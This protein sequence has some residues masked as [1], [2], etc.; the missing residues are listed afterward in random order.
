M[1][2]RRTAAAIVAAVLLIAA[3]LAAWAWHARQDPIDAFLQQHWQRPLAPQGAPPASFSPLEAALSPQA[4]G[5]CHVQQYADWK[6]SLHSH[7]MEAGVQWQFHLMSQGEANR[8]MNCHAPLAEQ[9]ALVARAR[10]WPQAPKTAPPA[11]VDAALADDGLVC[12]GCHVRAHQ[13]YGPP[14]KAAQASAAGAKA[15]GGYTAS[16]AFE[17]SRFCASCHQFPADGPSINGKL[18][19]DTYQQWKRSPYAAAGTQCQG[20][21][22]PD[23]RHQWQ[24]IHSAEMLEKALEVRLQIVGSGDRRVAEASLRNVGAGHDLPTYMVPKI[25]A[26][27]SLLDAAGNTRAV[28]SQRVIG[29]R[30][31]VDL[32]HEDFDTRLAPGA[33]L[34]WSS[35]ISATAPGDSVELRVDVAPREHYER[36]FEHSLKDAARLPADT[37]ALLQRARADAAA[38]RYQAFR[39]REPLQP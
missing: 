22:M 5:R 30:V 8:C 27:L 6:Q 12:A 29:W 25:T 21:H 31:N 33:A 38:T 35:A 2:R 39:I 15:H 16:A 23:R 11:F 13:R 17:D 37:L 28:L 9:K 3:A 36:S 7:T 14:P 20:C 19:E 10:Q 1:S 4:C 24:G 18:H 34:Q 32:D 26:T